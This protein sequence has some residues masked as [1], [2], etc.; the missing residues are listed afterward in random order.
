MLNC[1]TAPKWNRH[2]GIMYSYVYYLKA[3][4]VTFKWIYWHWMVWKIQMCMYAYCL[5]YEGQNTPALSDTHTHIRTSVPIL[6]SIALTH[7]CRKQAH[8]TFHYSISSIASKDFFFL[9]C[10]VKLLICG[11]QNGMNRCVVEH[12]CVLALTSFSNTARCL[13]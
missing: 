9:C 13:C 10:F 6:L 12:W 3:R 8:S 1:R 2:E 11:F 7:T 4:C 5:H